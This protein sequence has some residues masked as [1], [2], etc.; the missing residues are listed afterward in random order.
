MFSGMV[1]ARA[2]RRSVQTVFI[3]H[4]P[5]FIA[6]LAT[7]SPAS[8]NVLRRQPK[9]PDTVADMVRLR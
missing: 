8:I 7:P 3:L 4:L 5:L 6:Y 2:W 9:T 1:L